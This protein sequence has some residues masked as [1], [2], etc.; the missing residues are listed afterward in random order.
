M[1]EVQA[2]LADV[3]RG[4]DP[5]RH[6][7]HLVRRHGDVDVRWK[8]RP[9]IEGDPVDLGDAE[10]LQLGDASR[11]MVSVMLTNSTRL[12]AGSSFSRRSSCQRKDTSTA[13]VWLSM[14]TWRVSSSGEP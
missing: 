9:G 13:M 3:D 5:L 6:I 10:L 14:G 7:A 11:A 4:L 2:P 12:P 8:L 1:P